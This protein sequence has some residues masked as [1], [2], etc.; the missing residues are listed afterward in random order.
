MELLVLVLDAARKK[1]SDMYDGPDNISDR[2]I[3]ARFLK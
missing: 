3:D 1:I 2:L